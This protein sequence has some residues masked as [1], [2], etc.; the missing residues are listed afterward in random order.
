M[1]TLL[2]GSVSALALASVAHGADLAMV[3]KAPPMVVPTWEGFYLGIDGG[4]TRQDAFFN[5]LSGFTGGI[6]HTF[7]TNKTGGMAGGYAGYNWQQRSFV[8]GVEADINWVGAKAQE[9]WGAP[10]P[11]ITSDPQSQE[12][13]WVATFRGRAGLDFELTLVYWTGGLA[14]GGVKNSFNGFCPTAFATCAGGLTAGAR[15]AGFLGR[16]DET[17]LDC[18][19][20][21]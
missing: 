10:G 20:R 7:S 8:Y 17:W 5:D 4:A 1:R 16:R 3:P 13:N 11:F 12:V 15:F 21:I 2:L 6:G 9:I 14:V 19:C 18:G